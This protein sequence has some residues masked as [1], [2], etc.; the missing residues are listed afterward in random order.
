MR[1]R[2]EYQT[3]HRNLTLTR[4]LELRLE[5][6]KN[7]MDLRLLFL[8]LLGL[9]TLLQPPNFLL[10]VCLYFVTQRI[11]DNLGLPDVP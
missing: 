9:E 6:G 5:T 2:V 7:F 11:L 8:V 1:E 4:L 10:K 3:L